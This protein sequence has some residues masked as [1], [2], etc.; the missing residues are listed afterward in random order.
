[1]GKHTVGSLVQQQIKAS[2]FDTKELKISGT[3][4]RKNMFDAMV[5]SDVP[6]V[7]MSAHGGHKST[8]SKESYVSKTSTAKK[9]INKILSDS[10]KGEESGKFYDIVNN[11]K[12][13]EKQK[14]KDIVSRKEH[15]DEKENL[16]PAIK[17]SLQ[18][19][20]KHDVSCEDVRRT[21]RSTLPD[22]LSPDPET[23]FQSPFSLASQYQNPNMQTPLPY[24]CPLTSR[25][26][27]QQLLQPSP[28]YQSQLLQ[29]PPYKSQLLQNPPYPSQLLQNSPY[30]QSSHSYQPQQHMTIPPYQPQQILT[31]LPKLP[32][33]LQM[34]FLNQPQQ[35]HMSHPNQP[36]QVQMSSPNQPQQ[37]QMS[38][39][40]QSQQ[41]QMSL[42][43]QPEQI[44]MN[45][46]NQLQMS[47][48]NQ[49]QQLQISLP[50]QPQ[51]LQMS[52]PNQ[53][54][55]FQTSLPNP[56]HQLQLSPPCQLQI[57]PPNWSLQGT[58]YQSQES[59]HIQSSQLQINPSTPSHH[60]QI[61]SPYQSPQ[62]QGCPFQPHQLQINPSTPS[63]HL[64]IS[65]PYQSPQL[66]GSPFQPHQLQ[67]CPPYQSQQLQ[68]SSPYQLQ[69]VQASPKYKSHSLPIGLQ[70]QFPNFSPNSQSHLA[71]PQISQF[72]VSQQNRPGNQFPP[73]TVQGLPVSTMRSL[74]T[75]QRYVGDGNGNYKAMRLQS[76][77]Y[78]G[79]NNQV[80]LVIITIH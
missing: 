62:L 22:K 44:Q 57:C 26:E 68:S 4:L 38:F 24:N 32:Q 34:N 76:M 37:L 8:K 58:P 17:R 75:E 14:I 18:E 19:P 46:S 35:L 49:S 20:A 51:Q 70:L 25:Y 74:T 5:E 80:F 43:N 13:K 29:N 69:Q 30:L 3:S 11:E 61:S 60:L 67:M 53:P 23:N 50:N 9:A 21:Q 42:P 47:L 1:M 28:S 65:S 33:E 55:Q 66:Q 72:P 78:G 39:P 56:S 54:Q 77:F 59:P 71:P 10:L 41:L 63:H 64:Q 48:P 52:P 45:P 79:V 36:R 31:S 6:D 40:N 27:S 16:P 73:D 15:S 7:L 12:M 2:G